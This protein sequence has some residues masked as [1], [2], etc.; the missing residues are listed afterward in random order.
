LNHVDLVVGHDIIGSTI[1]HFYYPVLPI[2]GC[3]YLQ[4]SWSSLHEVGCDPESPVVS[5]GMT[6]LP[7]T[8]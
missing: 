1:F 6:D 8:C 7:Y 5:K 2:V 3:L 4:D